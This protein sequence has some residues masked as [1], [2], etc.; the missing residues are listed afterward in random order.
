MQF[1]GRYLI[2]TA[3]AAVWAAL[4]DPEMLKKC[5]PGCETLERT[6]DN[7]LSGSAKL[8]IGPVSATFKGNV[9]LTEL[10]PPHRCVL[11][12]EG[13]GGVAGFAKGQAEVLLVPEGDGT[14]LTYNAKATVG[15]KLAQVGQRLIDG[16]ARQIADE[17]FARFAA[18]LTA[19]E[20]TSEQPLA[21]DM[22]SPPQVVQELSSPPAIQEG[23]AP[24]IWV[25][26]LIAIIIILLIL[27]G[28]VL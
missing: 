26:G 28:L 15:G 25:V 21:N 23:V 20:S 16:A 4:N 24:Q 9:D 12:G 17:F 13:Q 22:A 18:E 8:K 11:K 3:P 19:V 5:I 10:D 14:E 2:A 7:R 1:T 27:F 6:A